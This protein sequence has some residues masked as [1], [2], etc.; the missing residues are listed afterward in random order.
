MTTGAV[1]KNNLTDEKREQRNAR[2]RAAYRKKK[3][4]G[5]VEEQDENLPPLTILGKMFCV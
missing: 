2:M 5:M 3:E 1:M 4:D